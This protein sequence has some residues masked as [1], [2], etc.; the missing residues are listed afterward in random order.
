VK[1]LVAL[2]SLGA[3]LA[4][5]VPAC[6]SGASRA[7]RTARNQEVYEVYRQYMEAINQERQQA[8]LPPLQVRPYEEFRRAPGAD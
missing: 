3:C 2:L 5:M 8:G 6:G 1:R 4:V 7:A